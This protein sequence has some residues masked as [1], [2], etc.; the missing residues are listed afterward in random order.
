MSAWTGG[1]TSCLALAGALLAS[2]AGVAC[3]RSP[4]QPLQ[5]STAPVA[6][7]F[8]SASPP[9]SPPPSP[10]ATPPAPFCGD[11][12]KPASALLFLSPEHPVKG[13]PVRIMAV[14]DQALDAS[15]TVQ[16]GSTT[17]PTTVHDRQGGPPY[18][19][20]A[21]IDAPAAGK[22]QA[23][24]TRDPACGGGEVANIAFTVGK[25]W[26][27]GP[28][29]PRTS[30]WLQRAEWSPALEDLYSA[31]IERMFDAP[32]DAQ[33]S[34]NALHEVLRDRSRN[35]LYDYLG[36]A[37]DEQNVVVR[38]DCADLPYFLRA[39]FAFK[40]GL[41]FGWSRCSRGDSS[42]PPTCADFATSS[43]PFPVKDKAE[44]GADTPPPALP[45]WADPN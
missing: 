44:V 18:H 14:T 28:E 16:S 29:T 15:L 5:S 31:W 9:P 39:Y 1:G 37:E 13:Q 45:A 30:L 23:Q 34:W 43:D 42:S 36:T 19:W 6:V 7:S 17:S 35:F 41:P 27:R 40:L 33:P 38:P 24:L 25:H 32:L 11:P 4:R 20:L 8:P 2:T 21:Q 26:P 10:V 3:Q 12:A 22:W